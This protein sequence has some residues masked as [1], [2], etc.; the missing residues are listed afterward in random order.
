MLL[1]DWPTRDFLDPGF[2]LMFGAAALAQLFWVRRSSPRRYRIAVLRA[3]GSPHGV[4][5]ARADGI[6]RAGRA[7]RVARDRDRPSHLRLSEAAGVFG[8]VFLLQRY[9]TRPTTGRLFALAASIVTHSCFATTTESIW[10][11]GTL[12]AWLAGPDGLGPPGSDARPRLSDWSCCWQPLT[13]STCRSTAA[14]G[15]TCRRAWNSAGRVGRQELAWPR[16]SLNRS[17]H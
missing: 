11:R 6:A 17:R 8:G 12:A 15:R 16:R 14:C 3:G 4:C 13:S 5:G 10:N 7:G 1:G 2:P 9:V